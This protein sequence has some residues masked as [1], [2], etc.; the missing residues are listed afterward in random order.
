MEGALAPI[1]RLRAAVLG[2]FCLD[3]YWQLDMGETE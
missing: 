3:S 2:D 1:R